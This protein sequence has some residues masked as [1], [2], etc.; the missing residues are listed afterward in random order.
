MTNIF[1]NTVEP[2]FNILAPLMAC[3]GF[4]KTETARFPPELPHSFC[5]EESEPKP[6]KMHTGTLYDG[7]FCKEPEIQGQLGGQ[8]DISL[9]HE[10]VS[11]RREKAKHLAGGHHASPYEEGGQ[12]QTAR[13]SEP[14]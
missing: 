2:R 11:S 5:V 14:Q 4:S 6:D 13:S 9:H 10:R 8:S 12:L 7:S 3:L 1:G